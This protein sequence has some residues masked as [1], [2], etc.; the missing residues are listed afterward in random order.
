M[1]EAPLE[2]AGL[3]PPRLTAAAA[4]KA[5]GD[6]FGAAFSTPVSPG[7]DDRK[8]STFSLELNAESRK[9]TFPGAVR[10]EAFWAPTDLGLPLDEDVVPC[11]L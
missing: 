6:F 4:E 5:A 3:D 7:V 11:L 8:E 10:L 9:A 2:A 1:L